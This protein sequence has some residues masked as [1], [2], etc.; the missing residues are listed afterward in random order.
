MITMIVTVIVFVI[1]NFRARF[2]SALVRR[3]EATNCCVPVTGL[4]VELEGQVSTSVDLDCFLVA[5]PLFTLFIVYFIWITYILRDVIGFQ[6]LY[7][8]R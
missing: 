7:K 8:V 3:L 6:T 4:E 1:V 2:V 5:E